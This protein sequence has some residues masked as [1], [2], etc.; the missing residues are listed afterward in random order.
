[1]RFFEREA[2]TGGWATCPTTENAFL[3]ILSHPSYRRS[4]GNPMEARRV[5]SRLM[6]APGHQFWPED[7]TLTDDRLQPKLPASKHLTDHFLLALAMKHGGPVCHVR[8][9]HQLR[10]SSRWASRASR[11]PDNLTGIGVRDRFLMGDPSLEADDP[12]FQDCR[13]GFCGTSAEG[14]GMPLLGPLTASLV[15]DECDSSGL[16]RQALQQDCSSG[17]PKAANRNDAEHQGANFDSGSTRG[18]KMPSLGEGWTVSACPVRSRGRRCPQWRALQAMHSSRNLNKAH[19]R[20]DARS[21]KNS[22]K[23]R[24]STRF[25]LQL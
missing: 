7:L 17:D 1:M 8:H 10:A 5:L 19:H 21:A 22:F 25:Q 18:R 12:I 4:L 24:R 9:Q 13:S 23:W 6:A 11:H 3:R 2:V 15:Q 16:V 20:T 14:D